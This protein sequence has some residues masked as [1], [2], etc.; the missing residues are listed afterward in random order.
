[1]IPAYFYPDLTTWDGSPNQDSR[2]SKMCTALDQAGRQ[3]GRTGVIIANPS[4][5]PGTS[6]DAN[7]AAAVARC[8]ELGQKVIGYVVRVRST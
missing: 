6:K 1:M 2:W 7:Y 8:Q 5:G 3:A 4:S